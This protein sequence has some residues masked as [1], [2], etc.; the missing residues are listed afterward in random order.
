MVG[1]GKGVIKSWRRI[2]P[3]ARK[4]EGRDTALDFLQVAIWKDEGRPKDWLL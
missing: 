2:V 3:K 1:M 4:P